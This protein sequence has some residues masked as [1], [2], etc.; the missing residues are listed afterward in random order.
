MKQSDHSNLD[1]EALQRSRGLSNIHQRTQIAQT[2]SGYSVSAHKSPGL[3]KYSSA[4]ANSVDVLSSSYGSGPEQ[5]GLTSRQ[6]ALY[7]ALRVCLCAYMLVH[8]CVRQM[9]RISVRTCR[10]TRACCR[11]CTLAVTGPAYNPHNNSFFFPVFE[12]FHTPKW[13]CLLIR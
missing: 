10:I 9:K 11:C 8:V 4:L 7:S 2:R 13:P 1:L 3:S 6:R 5:L 12:E